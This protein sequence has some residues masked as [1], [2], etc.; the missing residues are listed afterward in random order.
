MDQFVKTFISE[1][2]CNEIERL[3]E[4]NKDNPDE[5]KNMVGII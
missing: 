4:E 2:I 5:L 1:K 3:E